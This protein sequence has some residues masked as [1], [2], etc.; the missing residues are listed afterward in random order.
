LPGTGSVAS[1]APLGGLAISPSV[2]VPAKEGSS[3]AAL[4]TLTPGN[5][6]LANQSQDLAALNTDLSK[7]NSQAEIIDIDRLKARQESAAAL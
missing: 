4:A 5:L 2:G 3:G 1:T 6:N 7:A